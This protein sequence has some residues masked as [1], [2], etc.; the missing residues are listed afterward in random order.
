MKMDAESYEIQILKGA[1][2]F[3]PNSGI[4]GVE[5][6]STFVRTP[7]NP[8]SHFVELYEQLE[9]YG[10]TVQDAGLH[11]AARLPLA[12]GFPAEWAAGEYT[13]Q[14]LGAALAFDFLFLAETF[15]DAAKQ[16]KAPIDRLLKMIAVAEIYALQDIGLDI[17][18][19]N[20][21]RLGSRFDVEEGADWLIRRRP[22]SKLTYKQYLA[23]AGSLAGPRVSNEQP[24]FIG[25]VVP[26]WRFDEVEAQFIEQKGIVAAKDAMLADEKQRHATLEIQCNLHL[27]Q[28]EG[29]LVESKR[30][31]ADAMAEL[32]ELKGQ[33][34]AVEAELIEHKRLLAYS[35]AELDAILKSR[36]WR[37]TAPL[38]RVMMLLRS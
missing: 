3:L 22:D 11:R 29:Q 37:I 34:G 26:K 15:D 10:F 28:L 8:R 33:L 21:E 27:A 23:G 5:S 14:P 18:L 6:E 17:L 7:R 30:Q 13:L 4:F 25:E 31:L 16:A 32:I 38:R 35:N 2:I 20:R 12:H 36:S 19:G 1:R 9:S 24:T